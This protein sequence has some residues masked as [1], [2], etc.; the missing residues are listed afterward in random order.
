MT[1]IMDPAAR[2]LLEH[3]FEAIIDAGIN[4]KTLRGANISAYTATNI[5]ESEKTIFNAKIKVDTREAHYCRIELFDKKVD[6]LN[7]FI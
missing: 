3:T 4:P 2:I 7:I 6:L 1:S 5:I